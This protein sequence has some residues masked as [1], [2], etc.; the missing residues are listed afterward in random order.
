LVMEIGDMVVK[1]RP[2]IRAGKKKKREK[3][4]R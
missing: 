4:R 2:V 3:R 1:G